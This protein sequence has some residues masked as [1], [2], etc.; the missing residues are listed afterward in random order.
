MAVADNKIHLFGA[1][2]NNL[3]NLDLTLR[4][5]QLIVIT[6][7]SGSGKSTL[8]FDT[9]YAEG[10]RRYIETFSPYTRQFLDRLH[11]PALDHITGVRP[12]LA[13][14]Q[15][16][17][18]TNSRSTVGT[19]T[20]INDYL[21]VIWSNLAGIVCP[22]C[23]V[24]VL[25]N[26]PP[27]I[28]RQILN[29]AGAQKASLVAVCFHSPFRGSA[30]VE[31]FRQ[32]LQAEG[33]SRY[34]SRSNK[35]LLS[36]EQLLPEELEHHAG[37]L[38][39]VDRILLSGDSG[40]TERRLLSSVSQALTFGH[41]ELTALLFTDSQQAPQQELVYNS[42]LSCSSCRRGFSP[43]RPSL[44]SFNSPLGACS[45][46]RGFG[47]TLAIDPALCVPNHELS[48]A[49]GAVACWNT[50]STRHLYRQLLTF[51]N[52]Q[53]IDQ[54][55]PWGNLTPQQ[56]L[57]I[58]YGPEPKKKSGKQGVRSRGT[59]YRGVFPWFERLQEKIY[60]MH[61]RVFLSRYRSQFSCP[62]CHGTRLRPEALVYKVDGQ[63]L[64]DIWRKPV[65]EIT[66]FFQKL[67]AQNEGSQF[68]EI[69]LSEVLSRL[70]YL[71]EIGLGYLTL[72]RQSRT[73][74]GGESQR[75]NLTTVVGSRLVNTTVVLDEPTIGLH[76]SDTGRLLSTLRTLQRAGN[77][78][79]V[80][81]HDPEVMRAADELLDLGPQA[82][83]KGGAIVYQGPVAGI[84]DA[85]RSLTGGFL[86]GKLQIERRRSAPDLPNNRQFVITGARANNLKDLELRF[87]LHH[88]TVLCG[89]SGS[90]KSSF[91]SECLMESYKKLS[92]GVSLKQLLESPT[93]VISGVSGLELF[94]EIVLVD[95]SPVGK[96]PRANPA[97]YTK[98]WDLLRDCLAETP[99][100]QRLGLTKSS[101]SFNVPGGRCP[102]C[103]G[104]GH[105]R[106]EMQFL[107]DV[108]V[109]C[110][111]C[112]GSRFQET[113]IGVRYAGKSVTDLLNLTL[114]ELS[115]LLTTTGDNERAQQI[116]K[117]ITPLL[118]LGLGY[119]RLGQPLSEISG[120][121]AQRLKLAAYLKEGNDK[122]EDPKKKGVLFVLDE[123]TTG[124]HPHNIQ[125]LLNTFDKLL[126]QGHTIL[127]VEHNLEV[128]RQADWI[129]ELGPEGGAGG[130]TVVAEGDP[131]KL[132][133]DYQQRRGAA[134]GSKTV[135]ALAGLSA[136]QKQEHDGPTGTTLTAEPGNVGSDSIRV[137]GARE[138][139]LKDI[140]VAIPKNTLT[141]ITGVSG[142]GKSSLA[143]D[144]IFAEGQRRYIDSLSPYARQFLTQ[145]KRAEVD[146]VDSLPPTVSISQ[147][148]APPMGVSTIATT[149]ELYQYLRLL[150]A[151]VGVQH[152]PDHNLP[153]TGVSAEAV[154][155]QILTRFS[156]NRLFL[157]APVVSGRKGYYN[158]LFQ[159][160]AKAELTEARVDG[161]IISVHDELRLERHKLHW[162]SLLVASISDPDRNR[163]LLQSAVEQCLILGNGA[164]EVVVGSKN[165]E[166]EVFSTARV[167]PKCQ[168][169][170]HE[171]DPQDFS[172]RSGRGVCKLCQG[173]GQLLEGDSA[174]RC[175]EC[176]G[177][178]IGPIGRNVYLEGYP[179]NRLASM[180]PVE[181]RSCLK[182]IDFD[183]RIRPIVD[184]I[185][186]D[187]LNRLDIID[188]V[189]L[190]YLNLDR[191]AHS[192]S[193]G[194]AQRLR[195]ARTLGSPLTGICY[196]LDEPTIGL[197]PADHAQLMT[198]LHSLRNAG[199]T[200]IVVEHDEDTI[201]QAD[202]VIDIGP[203][204]GRDGGKLVFTGSVAELMRCP[205]SITGQALYNR[206]AATHQWATEKPFT[207]KTTDQGE[208]H[209][210]GAA[211]NNLK[212]FD[213]TIP[214]GEITVVAG[215]SGAGKS[216]LVH[217]TLVPGVN[218]LLVEASTKRTKSCGRS[219][220]R[221]RA[222]KTGVTLSGNCRFER[223]IEIDQTPIG[224]TATST[225]ASYLGVFDQIRKV[226]AMLP[227]AKARGWSASHFSFNT[228]KG[229]CESCHGRGII[230]I[231]MSF[232]PDATS[233]C[234]GC[235]GLRYS[236][237]TL[238]VAYQD[239]SIGEL[240]N[241]TI[242]EARQILS[243][244]PKICRPLDY[245]IQ[246]GLGYLTL[247]Q[248]TH[249]LSG[250]E[251]QR[252][253]IACELGLREAVDTIYILDEPTIGLHMV[254]V[255]KLQSVLRL[256]RDKGNTIIIIEHNLDVIRAA[257]Y[258]VELGPGPGDRGG[259]LLFAGSPA[260]LINGKVKTPTA[261]ALIRGSG[262]DIEASSKK[263]LQAANLRKSNCLVSQS[264]YHTNAEATVAGANRI[265]KNKYSHL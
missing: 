33:F 235:N 233:V 192:I 229:R 127:C 156:G 65:S 212:G 197:H 25:P 9:I 262:R 133:A 193:G 58:L 103:E 88:L 23:G 54:D 5:D 151:K 228:G 30:S 60:K 221:K 46:C 113:V 138:H 249:T 3:Q 115:D 164:V 139:N 248:P 57:L 36:L 255:E 146:L 222:I 74:S 180:T 130:G 56:Q 224:K 15:R 155:E 226:Y 18:I 219:G 129:I 20:E 160:A 48:V 44:F 76:S 131:A 158:D 117:L 246:L 259:E 173:R 84:C 111:S 242:A 17:R 94:R 256:L 82:G 194:E 45:T 208:L 29:T 91:V 95:Q 240:L 73:L 78:V 122:R 123:P 171:L 28:S 161:K 59:K 206:S 253:K 67:L 183:T 265:V 108:F 150:Y 80:V 258:L 261:M 247:G 234:E 77:T 167:C 126:A 125:Q 251:A 4:H 120:G 128:I 114:E 198:M 50:E 203:K 225:P 19:V 207:K 107:A 140:S 191:D 148:T 252:I 243:N 237:A 101:F 61:V 254:D 96:T 112:G 21:K 2:E 14:E 163:R 168:R 172:F 134:L 177:A 31:S 100:A 6:G 215:V 66:P 16:N 55:K 209:I 52:E 184:P 86:S 71:N 250:G 188:Q 200:V 10:G 204:G 63:T 154:T 47:N 166:P 38:L 1:Q 159:R 231:P 245:V 176:N 64:P 110:Q 109:Q 239:I 210:L 75:V 157:F 264:D 244:H 263:K 165:G 12:A 92:Q 102:D 93:A 53:C 132:L 72:D 218:Q 201:L 257:D 104:S 216:S 85:E 143:F 90:G 178:R 11:Q 260:E 68:S 37:L 223:L 27:L 119:L 181:L 13:L 179:I 42:K 136:A 118:E 187:L 22:A 99:E 79:I 106:I 170:F 147:K 7:V 51:C 69:A 32:T 162:I 232:L 142:S 195:L 34:Y 89:V 144:I 116:L 81:E 241:K 217:G 190:S 153:I 227:E 174:K 211:V 137:I 189:G 8:A 40:Q 175:P 236:D 185:L 238:E 169:G 98:A 43:P 49:A 145:L 199:N 202:H 24:E 152:C 105:H 124:L 213:L 83:R 230:K 26:T 141:V 62:D 41:G 186:A 196:V 97:T 220:K 135:A 70:K 214:L 35:L 205:D 39:A 182:K 149:T 87:P 121:E